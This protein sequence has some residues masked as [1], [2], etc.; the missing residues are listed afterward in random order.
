LN[1]SEFYI[2]HKSNEPFSPGT[3]QTIET[4]RIAWFLINEIRANNQFIRERILSNNKISNL[5]TSIFSYPENLDILQRLINM[6]FSKNINQDLKS[7]CLK[8]TNEI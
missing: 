8:R 6:Q 4:E 3:T 5:I 7:F 2:A 1:H